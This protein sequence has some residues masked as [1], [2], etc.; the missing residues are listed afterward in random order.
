MATDATKRTRKQ[1]TKTL[2][3]PIILTWDQIDSSQNYNTV[4]REEIKFEDWREEEM[5]D[6]M[7]S[8]SGDQSIYTFEGDAC[9]KQ[10]IMTRNADVRVTQITANASAL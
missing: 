7:E 4:L 9:E 5:G 2:L 10:L 1:R 8:S 3:F 6:L